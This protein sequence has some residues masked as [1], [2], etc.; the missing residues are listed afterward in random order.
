MS[1][2]KWLMWNT[3]GAGVAQ[4]SSVSGLLPCVL[5]HHGLD[6]PLNLQYNINPGL[7]CAHMHSIAGTQKILTFMSLMV[8]AGNKMVIAGNKKKPTQHAPSTKTECDY[9]YG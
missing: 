2:Q 8:I 7:V 5:Q 4:V 6:P 1:I 9:L 3:V